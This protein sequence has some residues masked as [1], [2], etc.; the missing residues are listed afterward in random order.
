MATVAADIDGNG[1]VSV[2]DL[3]AIID[4]WGACSGCVEDIDGNGIVDV[5]DLLTVVGAWGPC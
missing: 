5:T 3:L 2:V 1:S 4:S